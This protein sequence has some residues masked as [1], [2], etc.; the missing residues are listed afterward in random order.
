MQVANCEHAVNETN[1]A[2]R[3]LSSVT[4]IIPA[5]NESR[6]LPFVLRD[7]PRVGRVIVVDNGSTDGTGEIAAAHGAAVVREERRGY[8]SACLAGMAAIRQSIADNQPAPHIVVFLDGDY[9]DYPN[10]LAHLVR[11]I[12]DDEA[13][14][15]LGSRLQGVRETGA[16][17]LESVLGNRLAC[18]LMRHFWRTNYTDL[19]PFRALEYTAL[20]RLNMQD[21]NFG[22]TVEMQI[23]AAQAGLRI[24]EVPVPYRCRIGVSKISGTLRGAIQA[25]A[26]ILYT[27]ARYR[28]QMWW[29][30]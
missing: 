8:G 29:A 4:V 10:L 19:G 21:T 16:M 20:C 18:C 23:K 28:W 15:V 27:I 12:Q 7:L 17:P 5:L 13:D 24:R 11:P 14:F 26:K 2:D 6:S 9:S 22:W 30:K 1:P 3:D 25:G